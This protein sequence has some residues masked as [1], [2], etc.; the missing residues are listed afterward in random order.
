MNHG[1][2]IWCTNLGRVE[3]VSVFT[4]YGHIGYL[5]EAGGK[6]RATNGN[7]SYGDFGSVS[8][9]I[10]L[11]EEAIVAYVDN[12]SYQAIIGNLIVDNNKIIALEYTN[13]GRDYV[14]GNTTYLFSGDGYGITGTTAVTVTLSL[15]HI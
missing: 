13:A 3:L 11:T 5:S 10:D 1:I 12:R 6:I 15:I 2:S 7:N 4:Y 9:G 8:E 14:P